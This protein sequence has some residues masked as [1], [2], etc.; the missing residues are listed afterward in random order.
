M[1]KRAVNGINQFTGW[2]LDQF[3]KHH[4]IDIPTGK[5]A[6]ASIIRSALGVKKK[7]ARFREFDRYG[8]TVK[9]PPLK[10]D[11]SGTWED[12]SFP[13]QPFSEIM[14]EP[15]FPDSMIADWTRIILFVPIL[16]DKR[17]HVKP[18]H[19]RIGKA[20]VWKPTRQENEIMSA[21]YDWYQQTLEDGLI[22]S[23]QYDSNEKEYRSSNLPKK[24]ETQIL[25]MRTHGADANDVDTSYPGVVITKHC[26]WLNGS[27]VAKLARDNN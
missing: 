26:F 22:V 14:D 27:Y 2:T 25:H 10:T 4:G 9:V 21:E 15:N 1:L 5:N 7:D 13:H 19:K 18:S 16:R 17:D 23:L 3:A 20:F 12:V 6:A 24:S 11:L 8:I